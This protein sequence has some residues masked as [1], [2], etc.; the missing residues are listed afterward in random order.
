MKPI[1]IIDGDV[2]A[3]NSCPPRWESKA[4]KQG[5]KYI[6]EL[7]IDGN[8]KVL[9]YTKEEDAQYL[10]ICWNNFKSNYQK[11]MDKFFAIESLMAV[12]KGPHFRDRIYSDY[13]GHR[14]K[15]QLQSFVTEVRKLAVYEGYAV[16]AEDREA[17]DYIRTWAE[18]CRRANKRFIICSIDKD[19][20]CIPGT[21]YK[22]NDKPTIEISEKEAMNFYYRQLLMGDPTDKIPG[23][24]GV[25][26]VKAKK[27]LED[28]KTEEDYRQEILGCYKAT[29]GE[30]WKDYLLS[31]GK[32][33]HIQSHLNDYFTL[34]GWP[35]I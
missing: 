21:H 34:K 30:E 13:K 12:A 14:K 24:P 3:Y 17:D 28:C 26:P 18:E 25:G 22:L 31:N 10:Q 15:N 16:F 6:R 27:Y 5:D 1:L 32:L 29:Y 33:I 23:L 9:E 4:S 19:L 20:K 2:L 11:L 7:D 35:I 8:N